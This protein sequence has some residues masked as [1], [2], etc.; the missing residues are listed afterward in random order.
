[1]KITKQQLKQLIKEELEAA[2]DEAQLSPAIA[3][4]MQ[5]KGMPTGGAPA[6]QPS[7]ADGASANRQAFTYMKM[8]NQA[9]E[10]LADAEAQ[11]ALPQV[12]KLKQKIAKLQQMI[13]K[14]QS[15][16]MEENLSE[17]EQLDE[18]IMNTVIKA[19]QSPQV[20]EALKSIVLP[21]I[22]DALPE[23]APEPMAGL[24]PG[25]EPRDAENPE[26]VIKKVR[27]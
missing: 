19:L 24:E 20:R 2:L 3:A 6:K 1:M 23:L 18:G 12:F 13:Q 17:Q 5:S 10:E 16:A 25:R 22:Q 14:A 8:L 15:G 7:A 21:I 26:P 27:Q 9:K 11:N 4:A